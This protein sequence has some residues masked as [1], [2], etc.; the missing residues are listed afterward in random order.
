MSCFKASQSSFVKLKFTILALV[1]FIAS[2][3]SQ[4]AETIKVGVLHSLSGTMAI[5]ETSLKD[6]ALMAIDEINANGCLERYSTQWEPSNRVSGLLSPI[7]VILT[8]E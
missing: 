8:F 2:T 7:S 5:S 6:V 3:P 1:M 4:A